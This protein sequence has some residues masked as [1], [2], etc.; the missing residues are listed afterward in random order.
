MLYLIRGIAGRIISF[1]LISSLIFT[2]FS[3]AAAEE[4]PEGWERF[5]LPAGNTPSSP[6]VMPYWV[7]TPADLKPGLPLV[8]YLH[9]TGGMFKSVLR[10]RERGLPT[11]IISGDVPSPEAIVLVP[12][13]P[14]SDEDDSWEMVLDSVI[15]CVE[16]VIQ[17]YQVDRSRIALVG[18]SL[19]G[20]GM[21]NLAVAMPGVFS[22]LL[23]IEGRVIRKMRRPEMF[24]GCEVRVYTAHRDMA[25]NTASA[26]N[27]VDALNEAGVPA[28]HYEMENAH[29]EL[30]KIIFTDEEVQEWLW[31]RNNEEKPDPVTDPVQ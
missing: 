26:V 1:L 23:C 8:V 29:A 4:I 19:G 10:E 20:V 22:R 5:E 17:E 9:S 14:G 7:Y 27:F 16:K 3:P 21:W 28:T 6:Y 11:L 2:A 31:L 13:H 30:P 25:V 15:T 18:F 12:Q 24:I